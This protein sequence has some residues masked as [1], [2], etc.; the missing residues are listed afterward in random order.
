MRPGLEEVFSRDV[1]SVRAA[2]CSFSPRIVVAAP[3]PPIGRITLVH[4][5][6]FGVPLT[7]SCADDDTED[8]PE[9]ESL[10]SSRWV[11]RYPFQK[12]KEAHIKERK[13]TLQMRS[14]MIEGAFASC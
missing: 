14:S 4:H 12:I 8:L 7:S 10:S 13:E 11:F 9:L 2:S 6:A 5:G 3:L 1:R